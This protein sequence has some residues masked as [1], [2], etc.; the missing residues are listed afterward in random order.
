MDR[1]VSRRKFLGDFAIITAAL[2]LPGCEV[3]ASTIPG[4]VLDA[5]TSV[6]G[7]Q[8][9][10][11]ITIG[12]EAFLLRLDKA[13]PIL[14]L[15]KYKRFSK[16]MEYGRRVVP[17]SRNILDNYALG[18]LPPPSDFGTID[19]FTSD[20]KAPKQ[21]GGE[22]NVY[23]AGFMTDGGS[24][25]TIIK[26]GETTF[27]RIREGLQS[28]NWKLTDSLFFTYGEKGFDQ[29]A[30][31]D[32]A[33]S[34][35]ENITFAREYLKALKTNYPLAQ[36]NLIGHSLGGLLALEA[37]RENPDAINN[38]ILLN[39]PIKGIEKNIFREGFLAWGKGQVKSLV[40]YLDLTKEEVT[41]YLFNL[42]ENKTYQADLEKF[43]ESFTKMGRNFVTIF[44]ED[45]AIVPK[46]SA[47]V[48]GAK[49]RSLT[50]GSVPIL[51]ALE[52]HGR[53][54]KDKGIIDFIIQIIGQN[55]AV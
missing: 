47:T 52:A 8:M 55:L 35:K 11:V 27:V 12:N 26:P 33:R 13:Y 46:E 14:D 4:A 36:F 53:P 39:A 45:D 19:K 24:V 20:F 40:P 1:E 28:K 6:D 25:S 9:G 18:K 49:Q 54:L 21:F 41:D 37:A 44:A 23:F 31:T 30:A 43:V 32:T 10:D 17:V 51:Q 34:P 3:S 38:L 7:L 42:W 2:I 5:K 22:I 48:K 29:Y 50:V 16:L 15:E